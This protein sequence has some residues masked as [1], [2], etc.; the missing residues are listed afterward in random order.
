MS[1][2][3]I[4]AEYPIIGGNTDANVLRLTLE[5]RLG[6]HNYFTGENL[7][8]GLFLSC[9]PLGVYKKDGYTTTSYRGF[10]G[11]NLHV[12]DM[13][14]FSQKTLDE[15]EPTDEQIK[16]LVDHVINDNNLVVEGYE[17]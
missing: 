15:F 3:R 12:K 16:R 2:Q 4:L 1:K 5:Y 7:S 10:S 6:G 17:T 14:R 11:S 9:S 13:K 8:R